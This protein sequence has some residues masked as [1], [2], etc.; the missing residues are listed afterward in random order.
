VRHELVARRVDLE[1][2][3]ALADHLAR[4]LATP[5]GAQTMAKAFPMHVPQAHIAQPGRRRQL[6]LAAAV[7]GPGMSPARGVADHDI[8]ARLG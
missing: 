4:R 6:G 7:R 8:E 3:D 1:R 2:I 5:R